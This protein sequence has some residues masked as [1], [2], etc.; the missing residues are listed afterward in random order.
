MMGGMRLDLPNIAA[1]LT[2][3]ETA[4]NAPTQF[5]S[6]PPPPGVA[7]EPSPPQNQNAETDVNKIYAML[8]ELLEQLSANRQASIQLHSLAAGV[9]VCV[10]CF[11]QPANS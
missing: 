9:K 6:M 5:P 2:Q 4:S 8:N 10:I 3:H 1:G 11:V 7:Q